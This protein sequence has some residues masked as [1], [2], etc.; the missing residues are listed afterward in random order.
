MN[1]PGG[2]I[3][4]AAPR[5]TRH[6]RAL[7][8]AAGRRQWKSTIPTEGPSRNWRG[9]AADMRRHTRRKPHTGHGEM[10]LHPWDRLVSPEAPTMGVKP[11]AK[12]PAINRDDPGQADLAQE[13]PLAQPDDAR[14]RNTYQRLMQRARNKCGLA[15]AILQPMLSSKSTNPTNP[16]NPNDFLQSIPGEGHALRAPAIHQ[17]QEKGRGRRH[18]P[19]LPPNLPLPQAEHKVDRTKGAAEHA[20]P[21]DP[22]MTTGMLRR[23]QPA[24][25]CRIHRRRNTKSRMLLPRAGGQ[26][27]RAPPVPTSI[28]SENVKHQGTRSQGT[29]N[30][31][32]GPASAHVIC[33]NVARDTFPAAPNAISVKKR[34]GGLDTDPYYFISS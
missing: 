4:T 16:P 10:R 14:P 27:M 5:P 2:T 11:A 28:S 25:S 29:H 18:G 15:L 24:A 17:R 26:G 21:T 34:G 9:A 20:G 33:E 32:A 30:G 23:A 6:M 7:R 3:G 1:T 31:T 19:V 13:S 22:P 12:G 8:T